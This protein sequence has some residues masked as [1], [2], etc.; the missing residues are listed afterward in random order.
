MFRDLRRRL[1]TAIRVTR[2]VRVG[3]LEYIS[4]PIAVPFLAR[5]LD[6][7]ERLVGP[8]IIDALAKIADPQAVSVIIAHLNSKD[9]DTASYAR[10]ALTSIDASTS[11]PTVKAMIASARW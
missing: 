4:D 10:S 3:L 6:A 9:A 11:D 8:Q 7:R 5:V 1:E 2:P